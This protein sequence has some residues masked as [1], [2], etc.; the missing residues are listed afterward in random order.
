MT[1]LNHVGG[2]WTPGGQGLYV[3]YIN[4]V[5]AGDLAWLREK[6]IDLGRIETPVELTCPSGARLV[7]TPGWDPETGWPTRATEVDQ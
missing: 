3:T 6:T 5:T 1:A 2:M 7:L 4:P